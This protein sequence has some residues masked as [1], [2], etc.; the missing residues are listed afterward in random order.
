MSWI[1]RKGII[2]GGQIVL[3]T[4]INLPDGSEV[5]INGQPYGKFVG[6]ED[7]GLPPTTEEIAAT[8]NAMKRFEAFEFMTEDEQSD[9]PMVVQEWIDDLRSIPPVP[10]NPEK[11]AEWREWEEKMRLFNIEAVRKQFEEG[12]P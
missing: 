7:N 5:T 4:P 8:L 3:E 2:R 6:C 10:E 12:T 11:E 1:V 9:D